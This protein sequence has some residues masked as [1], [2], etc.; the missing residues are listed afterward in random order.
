MLQ[1][2]IIQLMSIAKQ[3][4]PTLVNHSRPLILDGIYLIF[5]RG[6]LFVLYSD[7]LNLILN[8]NESYEQ[9]LQYKLFKLV[10]QMNFLLWFTE[11][12]KTD[13]HI[14]CCICEIDQRPHVYILLAVYSCVNVYGYIVYYSNCM[15]VLIQMAGRIFLRVSLNI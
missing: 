8:K 2:I 13:L 6:K 9:Y 3:V 15:Q 12:T 4:I 14:G 11:S 5:E 1:F 7:R 10:Q